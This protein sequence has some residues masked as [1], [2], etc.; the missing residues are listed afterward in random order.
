MEALK[1]LYEIGLAL[2]KSRIDHFYWFMR[3]HLLHLVIEV[4]TY[5]VWEH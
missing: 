5:W 1:L 3:I 2:C 4:V